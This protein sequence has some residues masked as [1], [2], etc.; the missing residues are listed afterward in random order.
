VTPILSAAPQERKPRTKAAKPEAPAAATPAP[1]ARRG[2]KTDTIAEVELSKAPTAKAAELTN[3]AK[4]VAVALQS[5]AQFAQSA[6]DA[7]AKIKPPQDTGTA[8]DMLH[9]LRDSKKALAVLTAAFETIEKATQAYLVDNVP[10]SS[11][12]G[13]VGHLA[14]A[15][16]V[17]KQVPRVSDWDKVFAYVTK[18][19]AFDLLQ[20]RLADKSVAER[21]ENGKTIPGIEPFSAIS[22]SVTKLKT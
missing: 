2:K 20:R 18:E 6:T 1:K 7:V 10:K 16:I 13:A 12:T 14:S 5:F 4:S 19:K 21:W 15:R 22:V 17:I 3:D 9:M 11:Q 8:A